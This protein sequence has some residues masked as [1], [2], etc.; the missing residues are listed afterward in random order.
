LAQSPFSKKD[1]HVKDG[2]QA[3]ITN[4]AFGAVYPRVEDNAYPLCDT[5]G[6]APFRFGYRRCA[7]K[8]L[9]LGFFKDLIRKVWSKKIAFTIGYPENNRK[10]VPV[11]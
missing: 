7:G 8:F 6:Y 1:F 4:S 2:M 3:S 10:E 11:C 5:A 9:T